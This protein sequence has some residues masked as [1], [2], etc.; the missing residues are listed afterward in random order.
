MIKRAS[1]RIGY[2]TTASATEVD[3]PYAAI[4]NK[5]G[6]II[7]GTRESVVAAMEERA[8]NMTNR[9]TTVLA[10]CEGPDTYPIAAFTYFIVHTQ[11]N[12]D[13]SADVELIRYVEW[14]TTT[15]QASMEADSQGMTSV[16][17]AVARKIKTTVF[18]RWTCNGQLLM[19][20]VRQQK[21]DE[22]ESL[23]TWKLPVEIVT[24]IVVVC[25]VL[26]LIYALRQRIQYIKMLDRDDWR[27]NFFDIEFYVPKKRRPNS[28]NPDSNG[29]TKSPE[30]Q[31]V[32]VCPGKWDGHDVVTRSLR[33]AAMFDVN[34]KVRQTLI[35]MIESISHENLARFY[36][37]TARN[38]ELLL[39]EEY[40]SKGTV[41]TFLH[42]NKHHVTDSFKMAVCCDIACGMSY[43]HRQNIIHGNLTTSCCHVDSRWTVKIVDWEYAIVYDVVRKTKRN[44]KSS[45]SQF[46]VLQHI[47]NYDE[48]SSVHQTTFRTA[49]ELLREGCLTEPTHEFT[50]QHFE[51]LLNY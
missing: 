35:R 41:I 34:R 12:V 23:K 25:I 18:D 42:S 6:K 24:P 39:V 50:K 20:L 43:L 16:S 51:Q 31:H 26:L 5:F 40:C 32:V 30:D 4:V 19:E 7:A 29:A 3:L 36:G 49:P 15:E 48:Q 33:I 11:H 2:L 8:G 46:S 22:D 14:F 17:Q 27:I 28:C 44:R 45:E 9:L 13:C 21:Y 10:D 38:D 1:Y 37:I 47:R